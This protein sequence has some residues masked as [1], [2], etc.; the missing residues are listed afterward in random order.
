[1]HQV[2]A[3]ALKPALEQIVLDK[4]DVAE[5]LLLDERARRIQQLG[6]DVRARDGTVRADPLTQDAKPPEAATADIEDAK[7]LTAP[8]TIEQRT[9]GRLPYARLQLEA[10]QFRQLAG[11]Q[12]G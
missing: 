6:V 5:I 11:Q 9:P 8:E 10:L 12:I 3:V 2:E 7:T 1:M 4:G